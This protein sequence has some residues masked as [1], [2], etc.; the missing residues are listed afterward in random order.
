MDGFGSYLSGLP[1][2]PKFKW[3]REA[4]Q[5]GQDEVEQTEGHGVCKVDDGL[6]P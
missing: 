3:H 2:F 4:F 5:K 1:S 6:L